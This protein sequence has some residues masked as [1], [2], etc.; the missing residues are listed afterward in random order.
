MVE[1]PGRWEAVELVEHLKAPTSRL[2]AVEEERRVA[3]EERWEE[4]DYTNLVE[5]LAGQFQGPGHQG[6]TRAPRP[7]FRP[8][9][10]FQG[11]A[12]V[13]A[14]PPPISA[15]VLTQGNVEPVNQDKLV[16]DIRAALL[17]LGPEDLQAAPPPT[18]PPQR[19]PP[20]PKG[21]RPR[22]LPRPP[23]PP[24]HRHRRPKL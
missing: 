9:S 22:R 8:S 2:G 6:G 14:A 20:R 10:E 12:P 23:L 18:A 1:E 16:K 19:A 7:T 4:L 17:A 24:R 21:G 11:E 5:P 3:E 13:V 15:E